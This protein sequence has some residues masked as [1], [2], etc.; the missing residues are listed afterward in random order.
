MSSFVLFSLLSIFKDFS[1]FFVLLVLVFR[2]LCPVFLILTCLLVFWFSA[3]SSSDLYAWTFFSV[4]DLCLLHHP[5]NWKYQ[6]APSSAFSSSSLKCHLHS[7]IPRT[8]T[9]LSI[10]VSQPWLDDDPK[11]LLWCHRM[12]DFLSL[13]VPLYIWGW[14]Q[15]TVEESPWQSELGSCFCPTAVKHLLS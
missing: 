12:L 2:A 6:T 9:P 4:S 5:V 7:Y 10:H 13:Q 11:S 14:G 3:C 1:Y 15:V 8:L